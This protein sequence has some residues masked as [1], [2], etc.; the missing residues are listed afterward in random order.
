MY[1]TEGRFYYF[2]YCCSAASVCTCARVRAC[3]CVR[4]YVCVPAILID[5]F[6]ISKFAPQALEVIILSENV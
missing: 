1:A 5:T 3:V 2:L 6:Y 4:V